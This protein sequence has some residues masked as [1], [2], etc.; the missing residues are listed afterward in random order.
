ML[1]KSLALLLL[2]VSYSAWSVI[3]MM[4]KIV[5]V[6]P[7]VSTTVTIVNKSDHMEFV[8]ITLSRLLNPGVPYEQEQME[9]V[10]MSR[11]PTLYAYPFRLS[12]S[13][14]QSK[15]ITLKPLAEVSQELVYRLEV[16]PITALQKGEQGEQISGGVAV[17][18]SFSALV[19]QL[20]K[21]QTSEL[22]TACNPGGVTLSASGT[23]RYTIKGLTTD[24]TAFDDFNLYPGTPKQ[25]TGQHITLDGKALC[26][27]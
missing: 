14:G 27:G 9:A 25:V 18:L 16:K 4:P 13:P 11:N 10:G 22:S 1:K 3:D 21:S 19:R 23:V 15:K 8:S 7:G 12:L 6:E 20:P 2:P 5:E 17:N 24:G 26:Q